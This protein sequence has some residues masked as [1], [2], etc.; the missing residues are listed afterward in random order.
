[1]RDDT[2]DGARADGAAR[3]LSFAWRSLV[4][5]NNLPACARRA[6]LQSIAAGCRITLEWRVV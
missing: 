5:I 4:S 6:I 2:D 3:P 1:L